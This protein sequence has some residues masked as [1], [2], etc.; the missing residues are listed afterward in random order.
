[1]SEEFDDVALPPR[2]HGSAGP[3][4]SPVAG[5]VSAVIARAYVSADPTLKARMLECL[6][7][8]LGVLS[9]LGVAA[10]AF[11]QLLVL[12]VGSGSLSAIDVGARF[13]GDQIAELVRFVE[14]VSP[15]ALHQCLGLLSLLR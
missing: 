10:G 12:R 5:D 9:L 2:P 4:S 6:T 3:A 14:Q 7:R 8:P 13:T 1:M 11:A 15:P